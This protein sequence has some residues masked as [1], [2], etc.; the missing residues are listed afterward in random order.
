MAQ[1]IEYTDINQ[2]NADLALKSRLYVSGFCLSGLLKDIRVGKHPDARVIVHYEN[3]IPVAVAVHCPSQHYQVQV[4]VRKAC[5]NRGIGSKILA[6]LDA[7][8]NSCVGQGSAY[9][10]S[11]WYKNKFHNASRW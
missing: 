2:F 9:S 4:F 11:F 5:R 10:S 1:K 3:S 6:E 7:P 8:Q